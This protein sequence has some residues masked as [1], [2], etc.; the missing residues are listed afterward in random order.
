MRENLLSYLRDKIGL[1]GSERE[2]VKRKD[3]GLLHTKSLD[4]FSQNRA[5]LGA[6]L[7]A[8][9]PGLEKYYRQFTKSLKQYCLKPHLEKRY[10]AVNCTTDCSESYNAVLK[11]EVNWKPQKIS[12]TNQDFTKS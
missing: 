3:M 7:T 10:N 1:K 2:E 9:Y 4:E 8:K 11:L 6:E 5:L 12:C